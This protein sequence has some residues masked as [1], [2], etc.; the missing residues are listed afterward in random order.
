M[1]KE[2]MDFMMNVLRGRVSSDLD[3][4]VHR[5][6]LPFTMFVTSQSAIKKNVRSDFFGFPHAPP[7][8]TTHHS[9][10]TTT[11]SLGRP[12]LL[13]IFFSFFSFLSYTPLLLY[14]LYPVLPHHHHHH[15]H[16]HFPAR[17]PENSWETINT[18]TSFF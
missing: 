10:H 5:T 18:F 4:L 3:D 15:F 16:H 6:N 12:S 1:M 7:N 14:P 9:S 11:T 2:R 8:P 17:S 13:L